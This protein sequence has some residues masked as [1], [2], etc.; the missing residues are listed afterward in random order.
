[1]KKWR[2]GVK[3]WD[4]VIVLADKSTES[5]GRVRNEVEGREVAMSLAFTEG[6]QPDTSITEVRLLNPAKEVV[7]CF[8]VMPQ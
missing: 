4:V 5:V 1:M 8:E 2:S 6:M 7:A 3:N